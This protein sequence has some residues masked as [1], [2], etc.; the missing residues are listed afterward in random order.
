MDG[1]LFSI[2]PPNFTPKLYGVLRRQAPHAK[3]AVARFLGKT[4]SYTT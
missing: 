3:L 4:T 1:D 2:Q